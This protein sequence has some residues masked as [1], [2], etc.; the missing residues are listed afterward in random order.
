MEGVKM[1]RKQ[2]GTIRSV[3]G[4]TEDRYLD[5]VRRFPLRPLRTDADL[6]AAVAVIDE[7]ID[8][9]ALTAPEQDYLDVL[10]DLV[11]S[12]ESQTIPMRPVGDADLLRFLIDHKGVSQAAVASGAGIA[13]STISEVLAGKRQLNRTQIAK[14][15]RYF[16]LDPGAFLAG[17]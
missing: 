8:R 11:E 5:L 10:S 13:E 3:Y 6:D 2:A 14:L 15:A 7:L 9:A 17:T 1:A 12:Y 16:G 4:K